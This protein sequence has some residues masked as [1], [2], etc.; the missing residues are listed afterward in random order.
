MQKV[1]KPRHK[2]MQL[3]KSLLISEIRYRRLF[4]TAQDGI[5]ILDAETGQIVDINPFL[6]EMLGYSKEEF[7]GK[8]LWEI[9]LFKN[10]AASKQSFT[11]LQSKK[12][13]RYENLPLERNDGKLIK[14]EFINIAYDV[15]NKK[16]VNNIE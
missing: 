14:V 7:L 10:V 2:A 15:D 9:G 5:L 13:M 8:K 16:V 6:I 11:E 3:E 1:E 4:E 12:Y